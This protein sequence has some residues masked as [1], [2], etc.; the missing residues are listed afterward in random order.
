MYLPQSRV[1][2]RRGVRAAGGGGAREVQT[3][4]GAGASA[5][6]SE[7]TSAEPSERARAAG[8]AYRW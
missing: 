6:G 2:P 4:G 1:C 5:P 3:A 7:S 8:G